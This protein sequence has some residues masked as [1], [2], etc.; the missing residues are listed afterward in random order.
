[1]AEHRIT[2]DPGL[3]I[4]RSTEADIAAVLQ[5]YADARDFMRENGNPEQW[6]DDYPPL[7][8]VEFDASANG[9]GFVCERDGEILSAFCFHTGDDP[10]YAVIEG[11]WLNNAP[12]GSMHRLAVKRG[13]RGIGGF[14]IGW[15]L[16]Q[17]GNL[18]ADTHEN[19]APMLRLFEKLGFCRCGRV[20]IR[21]GEERIAFQ[22]CDN[23][24]LFMQ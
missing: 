14:C 5:I 22:K 6:R 19:N 8:V 15:A 4:R 9:Q 13:G 2:P 24:Y 10:D 23:T 17:C 16:A 21:G 3:I 12:Y 18:R 11:A 7:E 1:M 20:W